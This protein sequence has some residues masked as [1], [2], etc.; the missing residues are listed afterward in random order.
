MKPW[1]TRQPVSFW[2]P[3]KT[4]GASIFINLIMASKHHNRL[5]WYRQVDKRIIKGK[6]YDPGLIPLAEAEASWIKHLPVQKTTL[7]PATPS[8]LSVRDPYPRCVSMWSYYKKHMYK[9]INAGENP[10]EP[11]KTFSS[12]MDSAIYKSKTWQVWRPCAYWRHHLTGHVDIIRYESLKEDFKRITGHDWVEVSKNPTQ[13]WDRERALEV[14]TDDDIKKINGWF[15]EDFEM[16]GYE[17][18]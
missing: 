17:K 15:N 2:H 16:F 7:D 3:P 14:M 12:W 1:E 8:I 11:V 5:W 9:R 18:V 6:D 10:K 13:R 4:A